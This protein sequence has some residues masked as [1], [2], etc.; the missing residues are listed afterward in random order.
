MEAVRGE[1]VAETR[2][3]LPY[4]SLKAGKLPL[5]GSATAASE[6]PSTRDLIDELRAPPVDPRL[7]QSRLKP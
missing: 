6:L 7:L 3:S 5:T 2:A 1:S 4:P